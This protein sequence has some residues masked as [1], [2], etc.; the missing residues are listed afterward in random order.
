SATGT[1]ADTS[2]AMT[3]WAAVLDWQRYRST[4]LKIMTSSVILGKVVKK[5]DLEH[6]LEFPSGE[7]DAEQE[8]PSLNQLI[9]H[10]KR[11]VVVEQEGDTMMVNIRARCLVPRYC[12]D[13]ANGIAKVYMEFNVEQLVGSG[14]A[15]E[16]W[17]RAQFEARKEALRD[18]EDA[19]VRFRSDRNLIS[20][21]LED[22]YN[23]TGRNLSSL[24]EKLLD[25]QYQVDSLE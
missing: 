20:V 14:I 2:D 22:Q 13:I 25:A 3:M 1:L 10:L 18:S 11:N 24:A 12:A 9:Q 5:L 16:N 19:L 21:S 17:L 8:P 7:A 6:D 4:Q 15:A 23:I